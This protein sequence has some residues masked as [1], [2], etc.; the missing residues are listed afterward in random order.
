MEGLCQPCVE[1]DEFWGAVR[2]HGHDLIQRFPKGS[3]LSL[4]MLRAIA[5]SRSN[6]ARS[7]A[8]RQL[9]NMR[10][11]RLHDL[12]VIEGGRR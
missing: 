11:Q 7:E 4:A 1:F 12:R 8:A 5:L 10:G 9:L 2:R 3:S 6:A